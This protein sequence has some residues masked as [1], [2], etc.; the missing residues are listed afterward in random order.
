MNADRWARRFAYVVLTFVIRPSNGITMKIFKRE[1]LKPI[2]IEDLCKVTQVVS[3]RA[4]HSFEDRLDYIHGII[5]V[6]EW[7]WIFHFWDTLVS[8]LK[9][10]K[11]GLYNYIQDHTR[12][13]L[14]A[15]VNL[16]LD[17]L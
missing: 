10:K 5:L 2:E 17:S 15:L 14:M 9:M 16:K 7:E 11:L 1:K 8:V 13:K 6:R 3:G 12:G 4:N